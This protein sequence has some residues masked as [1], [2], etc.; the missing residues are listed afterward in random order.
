[1]RESIAQ[2]LNCNPR[3]QLVFAQS[4]DPHLQCVDLGFKLASLIKDDLS[5][6]YLPMVAEERLSKIFKES[7]QNDNIIGDY[8]AISNWGILFEPELKLNLLSLF[9]S[10]SKNQTL[11]L[12]NCGEFNSDRFHLVSTY[13]NTVLPLGQLT[14]CI[15]HNTQQS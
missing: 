7:T 8:I 12:V 9:D 10:Y 3:N 11:I 2:Y 6:P 13:F 1:M 5:S 14:P 15:I 4:I